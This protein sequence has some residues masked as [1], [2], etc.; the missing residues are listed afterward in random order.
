M[1]ILSKLVPN[2]KILDSLWK[3]IILNLK[4][5]CNKDKL[6]INY[7]NEGQTKMNYLTPI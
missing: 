1:V 5:K 4:E 2:M 7:Y 3:L 6:K